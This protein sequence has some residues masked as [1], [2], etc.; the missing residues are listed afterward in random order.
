MS[1]VLDTGKCDDLGCW[2]GRLP[3][4]CSLCIKGLKSVFFATGVCGEG[5]FYCPISELR[6]GK[7][8][9]YINEVFVRDM[10]DVVL[11]VLAS[12]SRGVG[13]TGGDPLLAID[14]VVE[15]VKN[16]K[17]VFGEGFHVH[18]YTTGRNLRLEHLDKLSN[19]GLDEL[20][21][22]VTGPHSWNALKIALSYGFDTGIEN[23]VLP[24]FSKMRGLVEGGYRL[25]VR[26]INLNE[27]EVSESNYAGILSRGFRV[28]ADGLTVQGS[29]EVALQIMN[30][31]LEEGLPINVHYCPAKFKDKYQYR[32]R[33]IKRFKRTRL[34]YEVL[35]RE[36]L[37]KF[38][39][40]PYENNQQVDHLV[41]SGLAF[42]RDHTIYTSVKLSRKLMNLIPGGRQIRVVE[43]YPTSPRKL[44]NVTSLTLENDR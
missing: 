3:E 6:R 27:M 20:R 43:A 41:L 28:N 40:A 10:K 34:P 29:R 19:A 1:R 8:A 7:R 37:V 36:G 42:K 44:L 18:M 24:D 38:V 30:W 5:C 21:I 22:H 39:E 11:E 16:L 9:S 35:G 14:S 13:I 17:E 2:I 15:V 25:G 32:R 4:G 31:V 33:L 23:P 26:F 12:G